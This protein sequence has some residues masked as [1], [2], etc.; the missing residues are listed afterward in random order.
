[1][2]VQRDKGIGG[3]EKVSCFLKEKR[4]IIVCWSPTF[5]GRI[6]FP[7]FWCS[8]PKFPLAEERQRLCVRV[9]L[10]F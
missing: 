6:T 5:T 8:L 2:S 3:S 7:F 9:G 10:L 1:M 4:K